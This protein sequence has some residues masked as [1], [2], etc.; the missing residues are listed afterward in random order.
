MLSDSAILKKI[1]MQPK[2]GASFKQL[3]RELGLHGEARRELSQR[4]E[5]LVSD[6]QLIRLDPERFALPQIATN[7]NL[8]TGKLSM[9]RD[10]YGFVVPDAPVGKRMQ[11]AG[12][13]FISPPAVGSALHADRVLVEITATRA[14]GRSE[15]RILR[16]IGRANS[17]V[18]GIF[19][20]SGRRNYVSPIDQKIAQ[21]IVIPQ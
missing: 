14:N 16:V 5:R 4:L 1:E 9:H 11:M 8:V 12:D 3:V 7:K 6:K 10:G 18:V 2:R 21:E 17:T 13:I 20:Y 15:G 19:H